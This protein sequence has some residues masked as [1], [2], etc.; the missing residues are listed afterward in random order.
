MVDRKIA[1]MPLAALAA[2][3]V[4]LLA[5]AACGSAA[6]PTAAPA[7]T[8]TAMPTAAAVP[9]A[10]PM[11][12]ATV[13]PAAT[14][15]AA[16]VMPAATMPSVAA[17]AMPDPTATMPPA[18][19]TATVRPT[20]TAMPDPT[21]TMPPTPAPTAAPTAEPLTYPAVPGIVD[22]SNLGW[23]REI[24]TAEG[25]ITLEG[26]PQRILTYSLGHDEMALALVAG[27][28]IAALGKFT[29]N[30]SYSNVADLAAEFPVYEKGAENVLAA[31]PD[32]FIV[33]RSTKADIVALIKE[34]GIPVA[35]PN[36]EDA[37]EGNTSQILLMGYLLGAEERALELAAEI[38]ERME[39][40]AGRVPPPGDAAR[41]AVI[42]VT[43]WSD[44]IS[45][46]GD[47]TTGSD[48]IVAA[49]GV[50]AAAA[51]G[52]DGFKTISV[53]SI[54]A[55]NPDFILIPQDGEGAVQLRAD[56]LADPVL[57]TVPAVVNGQIHLVHP[58]NYIVL[59]HW[60]VRGVERTAQLLYP[61]RFADVTF[62]D[63][64]PYGGD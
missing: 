29:G 50:N 9:T 20:A 35:R 32:L 42:S 44:S 60:T 25:V 30:P 8:A 49:G 51:E 16:T 17:T 11:P 12:A 24:E 56:L 34:A 38:R 22:P 62:A 64:A 43:R 59:S 61:D 5:V 63:F 3:L 48:I 26:P 40:V 45:I 13:M 15:P 58:P 46:A 37:A 18:L 23:P 36:L 21:A 39:L 14:M 41:P 31:N 54:L 19:P 10:T 28:R 52:I 1:W 33:S 4:L 57:A 53:E 2:I 47:G 55:M 6:Q 7:A 27:E